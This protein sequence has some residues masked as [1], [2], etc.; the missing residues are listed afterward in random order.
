MSP[1]WFFGIGGIGIILSLIFVFV[2]IAL[3]GYALWHA[4]RRSEKWWFIILLIVNT[5]GILELVY[6]IFV[7][8]KW[9]K[10][11]G[12]GTPP[13]SPAGTPPTSPTV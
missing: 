4:A 6:L 10:F 3:K 9:H 2:I 12:S 11:K 13:I 8:G 1:L 7:V 5:V